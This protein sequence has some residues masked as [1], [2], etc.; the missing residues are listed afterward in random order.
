[1]KKTRSIR[2]RLVGG[3]VIHLHSTSEVQQVEL[4]GAEASDPADVLQEPDC[5]P[6]VSSKSSV[7]DHPGESG[8]SDQSELD[9]E[10]LVNFG[11][12]ASVR[13]WECLFL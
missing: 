8:G 3:A 4:G 13:S 2:L 1:V 7:G 10:D 11:G 12:L 6:A 5:G 9:S